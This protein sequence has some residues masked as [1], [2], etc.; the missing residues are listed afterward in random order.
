MWFFRRQIF[1]RITMSELETR[2]DL[3]RV[4]FRTLVQMSRLHRAFSWNHTL[5]LL[6]SCRWRWITHGLRDQIWHM[7]PPGGT[8][9]RKILNNFF[10]VNPDNM[11][12][13]HKNK[14]NLKTSRYQVSDLEAFLEF[15]FYSF[16]TQK[17]E[18]KWMKQKH[19]TLWEGHR[20]MSW[21][22]FW[23]EKIISLSFFKFC[24][25]HA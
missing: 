13:E 7:R 25:F 19:M 22:R 3:G 5:V 20:N 23:R 12:S 14:L 16:F 2:Y 1:S 4:S 24:F 11:W 21:K 15:H 8:Q 10:S 17:R 6:R 18:H 9:N